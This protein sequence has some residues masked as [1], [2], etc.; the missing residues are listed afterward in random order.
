MCTIG[1]NRH[2]CGCSRPNPY[3]LRLCEYAKL[4]GTEC[5]DFQISEDSSLSKT[6]D[7]ACT[8]HS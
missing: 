4:K 7:L 3:S 2:A 5:P 6:C 8:A 1:Y